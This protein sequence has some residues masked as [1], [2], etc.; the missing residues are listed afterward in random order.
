VKQAPTNVVNATLSMQGCDR[1]DHTAYL[2]TGVHADRATLTETIRFDPLLWE[3]P[4][5]LLQ[6]NVCV[7]TGGRAALVWRAPGCS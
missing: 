4:M 6:D 3:A 2:C 7:I 5:P 1:R